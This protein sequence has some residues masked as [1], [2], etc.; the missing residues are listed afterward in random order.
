MIETAVEE[1]RNVKVNT[2]VSSE[3]EATAETKDKQKDK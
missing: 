1:D 2:Y 3:T